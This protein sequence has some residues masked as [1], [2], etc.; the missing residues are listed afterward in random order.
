MANIYKGR[1]LD[2]ETNKPVS[3]RALNITREQYLAYISQ[4]LGIPGAGHIRVRV[5]PTGETR[6]VYAEAPQS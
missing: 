4:S 3:A 5:S 6:R 2:S 1:L